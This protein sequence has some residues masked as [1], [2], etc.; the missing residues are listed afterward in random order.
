MFSKRVPDYKREE[1]EDF[2][3]S[4]KNRIMKTPMQELIELFEARKLLIKDIDKKAVDSEAYNLL[5]ELQDT[6]KDV[7][8]SKEKQVIVDAYNMATKD[9]LSPNPDIAFKIGEQYYNETFN[10]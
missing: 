10:Q 9:G 6:L 4:E 7:F 2:L 8:L 1:A 3:A 5:E